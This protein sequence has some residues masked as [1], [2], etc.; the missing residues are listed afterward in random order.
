MKKFNDFD[1]MIDWVKIIVDLDVT[2]GELAEVFFELDEWYNEN[3]NDI[4]RE[5]KPFLTDRIK[6]LRK[7]SGLREMAEI[8]IEGINEDDEPVRWYWQMLAK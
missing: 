4:N 3:E 8:C 7:Y 5:L 1:K 2:A 6:Q